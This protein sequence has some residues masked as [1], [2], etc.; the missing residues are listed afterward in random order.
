MYSSALSAIGQSAAVTIKK[1]SVNADSTND[2]R[3]FVGRALPNRAFNQSDHAIEKRF[4]GAGRN[5]DDNAIR[6][7][8]RA[9][10]DAGTIAAGLANDRRRFAGDRRFVD[11]GH[12][13]DNL[14]VAGNDMSGFDDDSIAGLQRRCETVSSTV[15]LA[16]QPKGRRF[17]ASFAQRIGLCLAAGF[18]QCGGEVGEHHRQEQPDIQGD[19]IADTRLAAVAQ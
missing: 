1:I 4:A 8:A 3:N 18:G 10:G 19:Q 9:A 15:P 11:R 12:A 13:F 17:L 16:R 14:A 6:K 7:H 2:K 5:L